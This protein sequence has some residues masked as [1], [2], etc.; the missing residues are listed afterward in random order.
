METG[1]SYVVVHGFWYEEWLFNFEW[2]LSGYQ[3]DDQQ[4][5]KYGFLQP[6]SKFRDNYVGQTFSV[7]LYAVNQYRSKYSVACINDLY[8]PD[9]RELA[10]VLDQTRSNGWLTSMQR[11]VQAL[12]SSAEPLMNPSASS[13]SNVRFRPEDVISYEPLIPVPLAHQI[14][15]FHRYHPVYWDDGH[16]P[17]PSP[18]GR[19]TAPQR[20]EDDGTPDRSEAERTRPALTGVKNGSLFRRH[21]RA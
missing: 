14:T 10:W 9:R 18:V 13:I 4:S 8:V 7:L 15:R 12:G 5:Y 3:P 11:Q 2:L 6:I 19:P 17:T 21:R 20:F 16:E 1:E